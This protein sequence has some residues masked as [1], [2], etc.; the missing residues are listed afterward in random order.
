MRDYLL[1]LRS[2]TGTL[3]QLLR[4]PVRLRLLDAVGLTLLAV[5]GVATT[6]G[7]LGLFR[8]LAAQFGSEPRLLGLIQDNLLSLWGLF[9]AALVLSNALSSVY[10]FLYQSEDMSLLLSMPLAPRAV[11]AARLT[12]SYLAFLV[13]VVPTTFG[14]LLALGM[15][16]AAAPAYYAAVTLAYL[17]FVAILVL[18]A[19]GFITAVMR[20]VPGVRLKRWIMIVGLL[21]GL[22]L[23]VALQATVTGLARAGGPA[24]LLRS[25]ADLR[26]GGVP[27]L[28]HVWLAQTVSAAAAG[29]GW[30]MA[31]GGVA[32]A[33][34]LFWALT[35]FAQRGYASG[36]ASGQ[37]T[38]RRRVRRK[39]SEAAD[40]GV[41]G[42]SIWA[43]PFWSVLRKDL[44]M[45]LRAPIQWYLIGVG[46]VVV[47][48][49]VL[50]IV[51]GTAVRPI[52]GGGRLMVAGLL[53]V[54]ASFGGSVF[55][56]AAFSREGGN[57]ALIRS[58]PMTSVQVFLAKV[59]ATL[60]V[61]LGV[62]ALGLAVAGRVEQL[63]MRPA[64]QYYLPMVMTAVTIMAAMACLDSYFADFSFE[65]GLEPGARASAGTVIKTVVALYGA[66]GAI[67]LMF[68]TLNFGSY[69]ARLAWAAGLAPATASVLG[70]AAFVIE[71]VGL[72]LLSVRLGARR[73][74][75]LLERNLGRDA[76]G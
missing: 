51:R 4:R 32:A 75:L 57:F 73:L 9:T 1:V 63:G 70:Y 25:L 12:W 5:A 21:T 65:R 54:G 23:V 20:F 33:A 36:W 30:T 56:G 72:T 58:W 45:T 69:Y 11:F 40:G 62:A 8:S 39:P 10:A 31:A 3:S 74:D 19:T 53:L 59:G 44:T 38:P 26:L 14:P 60:P 49:Q 48:F 6:R 41:P 2:Q 76:Q 13:T 24:D 46:I 7:A 28:P 22:G 17:V 61:P 27:V 47:S 66:T 67:L 64:G 42:T 29:H 15:V 37:E 18:L 35:A 55:A 34:A 71:S 50:S 43:N 16:N 68:G 52:T